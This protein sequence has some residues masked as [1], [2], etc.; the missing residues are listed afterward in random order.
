MALWCSPKG[1][2]QEFRA[3]LTG[4]VTDSTG[5]VI[6]GA[7]ITAVNVATQVASS[8][9]SNDQGVY[10]VLYI[11]PGSYTVTVTASGFQTM[12]YKNVVLDTS[13]QLGL[14]VSL[15]TGSVTENIQVTAEGLELE[16][17]SA[18]TGGVIDQV[19][20]ENM[21]STGLLVL[22]DV[23][24]TQGIRSDTRG[25]FTN[26]LRNS[27]NTYAV[28]GAQTDENSFYMNGAPV[29]D[30]GVWYFTPNQTAVEQVEAVA[31]PYDAQYGRTGGGVLSSTIKAGTNAFHGAIYDYLGNRML[32]ANTSVNNLSGIAKAQNTRN[33]FGG[34]IGGPIRRG[35]TF[36]LA[37][38]EGFR[39][40]TAGTP[41][42]TVPTDAIRSG[43]FTGS[44]YTIYD[45]KSTYCKT[46]NAS[47]GCTAYARNP[48]P[49]NTISPGD[50]S[51]IGQA[52]LALYPEPNNSSL[53]NN[54][55][56][57]V[58]N[59]YS[60]D[61]YIF[62]VDQSFSE[63]TRL[64]AF[65]TRQ[66][67]A[68]QV[69]GNGLVEAS[70]ATI[71]ASTNY[72][73]IVDLTHVFS[74][75]KVLDLKAFY[76][77]ATGITTKGTALQNKFLAS[78]LGFNMPAVGTTSQQNIVPSMTVTGAT[79][80]FGNTA[81]G[82]ADADAD[83]TAS[84]TQL[85]GRHSLHYGAEFM[86]I[87]TAPTGVLG[88]PNGSFTFNSLY[89][90][91][92]PNKA[93][94]G[95][96][97]AFADILLGY[98][99]SG[100]LT[101]TQ[102]TFVTVHYY[103]TYI[104]D[105]Y[106]L[107]S[108]FTL[109]LGLRW[110][111]NTSPRDRHDRIN[112]GFCL[113]CTNPLTSQINFAVAP[114]L[115]S[116]LLG[117][118]QFAGTDGQPSAPF[119]V[120]WNDWQPRV[121]F[122]WTALQDTVVRGGYGIYFPWQVLDVDTYGFSQATNY[123]A[124]LDGNLTPSSYFKSGTPYPG[125]AVAPPGPSGGLTTNAGNAISFNDPDRKLRMSQ[126]WSLGIQ[127][128]MPLGILLD[129]QYLGTTVS[130]IPVS[131]PLDVVSTSLQQQCNADLSVCNTNVTNPFY[132]VLPATAVLGAS[133][134]IPTW[135]LKRAYPLFNGVTNV[136]LPVGSS[137]YN[138]VDVR[139][140]R[141]LRSLNFAF[142]YTYSNWMDRAS[143]L[144]SG[145]FV[146]ANLTQQLDPSDKRNYISGNLVY[147]VPGIGKDGVVGYA[148]NGWLFS[149]SVLWGTGNPLALPAGNFALGTPGCESYAPADGQTRA[150][151]FNNNKAC[152]SHLGT[153]QPQTQPLVIGNLRQPQWIYWNPSLSK[154]FPLK[155]EGLTARFRMEALNGANVPVFGAPSTA[156]DTAPA[157]SPNTNWTGFGTL[158][159]SQI[160][161]PRTFIASLK[162]N[163]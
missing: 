22:D 74:P 148:T 102:P 42:D 132:K 36:F 100:S 78:K 27:S 115:Q 161:T 146:D 13:Q 3:S 56:L 23:A 67:N 19:K 133:S 151:W 61:Q 142:N 6:P 16:T 111:V 48:Y 7:S 92:D 150:H 98:P 104:Q 1:V 139:L 159:T 153:W 72:D 33:T 44:G 93:T 91:G 123:I 63:N 129:M 162:I 79:A 121:G 25:I 81:N 59:T 49:N 43:N 40:T 2:A 47:G 124:S 141:R 26:T 154:T 10:S 97:H 41:K 85:F 137:H 109:S 87:Q 71:A 5:A 9:K 34:L 117:G 60:Y 45:P 29:S 143:Y 89:T 130:K 69:V 140:E 135:Q 80:L 57:S 68:S 156:M 75:S 35:K 96:G 24:F 131:T 138:A 160:N 51:P 50:I 108:K 163:F 70:T 86:D 107:S 84:M 136:N 118:L 110:D 4:Q 62:R 65:F 73:A 157:F 95:Q 126:H 158:P 122:S 54:H 94:S 149:S 145:N 112:A 55:V 105:T 114:N 53:T 77:H 14:N 37:S 125:G 147:P 12:V 30:Q 127:R 18:T 106:Q 82:T 46:K 90:Q 20:V 113:T 31:F 39:Q 28:S 120:H 116:P 101:W 21:P 52:I 8:T 66:K 155:R 11:L 128:K 119:N 103:G 58:P 83:F 32:N 152:W 38:Y 99:S 144:N 134:T 15:K 76:G 88:N 64:Y 17:V